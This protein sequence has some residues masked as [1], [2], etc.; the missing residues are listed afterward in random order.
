[1]VKYGQIALINHGD[2]VKDSN[3]NAI[4]FLPGRVSIKNISPV[5]IS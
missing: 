5:N 1:M 4:F 3:E 2:P